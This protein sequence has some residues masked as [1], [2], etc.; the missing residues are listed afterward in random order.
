MW[1]CACGHHSNRN[2]QFLNVE[3]KRM[4]VSEIT[5]E[6]NIEL[7]SNKPKKSGVVKSKNFVK[8]FVNCIHSGPSA[9]FA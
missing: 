9:H 8:N 2:G 7:S 4:M 5:P 1:Y 3:L 6:W